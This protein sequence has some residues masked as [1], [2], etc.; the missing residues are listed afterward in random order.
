[1]SD[2]IEPDD[3]QDNLFTYVTDRDNL[4][5]IHRGKPSNDHSHLAKVVAKPHWPENLWATGQL[6]YNIK[7]P[8]K[9]L[10]PPTSPSDDTLRFDSRFESGNLSRAYK[11]S[12][13]CY[14]LILEYDHSANGDCM[15][16]YFKITNMRANVKYNFYISGFSKELILIRSAGRTIF[17]SEKLMKIYHGH[18]ADQSMLLL[19]QLEQKTN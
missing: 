5:I 9:S 14:H 1:M 15:W 4:F 6:V 12:E 3:D 13:N 19:L 2:P 10:P 16:F 17:Q 8:E 7:D 18:T 11:L